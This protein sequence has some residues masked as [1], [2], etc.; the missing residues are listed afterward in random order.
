MSAYRAK[1]Y[2][3]MCKGGTVARTTIWL[4]VQRLCNHKHEKRN[5]NR[6]TLRYFVFDLR[7]AVQNGA[8]RPR[9]PSV[10]NPRLNE[11]R[12]ISTESKKNRC[13]SYI[14]SK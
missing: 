5:Q 13:H 10:V 8:E 14:V 11:N 1:I 3:C 4:H 6:E 12:C 9:F 2:G 7:P